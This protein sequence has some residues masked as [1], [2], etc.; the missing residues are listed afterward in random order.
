MKLKLIVL[1]I[2]TGL[3]PLITVSIFI[4]NESSKQIE[5]DIVGQSELFFTLIE[6][7][8]NDFYR[9]REG[10]GFVI[11]NMGVV[12][13]TYLVLEEEGW[14]S[15]AWIEQRTALQRLVSMAVREYDFLDIYLTDDQG[16]VIFSSSY[17]HTILHDDFSDREYIQGALTGRQHWSEVEFTEYAGMNTITV[18][19]PVYANESNVTMGTVNILLE[20][21]VMDQIVHQGMDQLGSTADSYMVNREGLL[22]TNTLHGEYSEDGALQHTLEGPAINEILVAVEENNLE[23]MYGGLYENYD[24]DEVL[25]NAGVFRLGNENVGLF[26]EMDSSEA[27]ASVDALRNFTFM[28][29]GIAVV[30]GLI[31]AYLLASSISKPIRAATKHAL[32]LAD[33]NIK[34]DIPNKYLKQKDEVGKLAN[35]LQTIITN[36]REVINEVNQSSDHVAASAEE[37]TA[38][39]QQSASVAEEVAKTVEEISNGASEQAKSTEDGS[40]KAV[41][42]GEGIE[43]NQNFVKVLNEASEK[44]NLVKDEGLKE[45]ETLSKISSESSGATKEVYDSIVKTNESSSKIGKASSVITDIADQTNLLALNAAIEAARA[46]DAGRGFAVVADEIRKL[47]EQSTDNTRTIDL[48]VKELQTNSKHAVE[49]MERVATILNEQEH[50]IKNSRTQYMQIADAIKEVEEAVHNLNVSSQEMEHMKNDILDTMQNLSA[51]AEQ[52]SASTQEVSAS[53]EEQTASIEEISN[54][55]E[56][57]SQLSQQLRSIIMKFKV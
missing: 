8:I 46:G 48:V 15:G 20:Q 13:D 31:I 50:S 10:D 56:E 4:I 5:E 43:H 18:S 29:V 52:N 1:F 42:L 45:I 34:E 14:Q 25:G 57:L 33:L 19:T 26:I 24:G 30:A 12:V 3:I 55:S 37:L 16:E 38:T 51:I 7:R 44:M 41:H 21:E 11:S 47:A 9:E 27:F 17:G 36:M 54:S 6:E 49:T 28:L 35:A 53:M 39:S 22:L 23:F 2:I 40:N 32:I